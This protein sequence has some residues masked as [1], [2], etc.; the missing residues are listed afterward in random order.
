MPSWA[1]H[2]ASSPETEYTG[3]GDLI[4][5][6]VAMECNDLE[7]HIKKSPFHG[8]LPFFSVVP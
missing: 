1:S 5:K 7:L 6:Q 8:I 2:L 4:S 3:F